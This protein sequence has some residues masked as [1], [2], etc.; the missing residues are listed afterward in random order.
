MYVLALLAFL[1]S[2]LSSVFASHALSDFPR[3]A[4]QSMQSK[5]NMPRQHSVVA[6]HGILCLEGNLRYTDKSAFPENLFLR[7]NLVFPWKASVFLRNLPN[8]LWA[9]EIEPGKAGAHGGWFWL[10][11][12]TTGLLSR[13]LN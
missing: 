10:P 11:S 13:N 3:G 7:K 4:K 8:L 12:K 2:M 9:P 6:P 5:N 1:F